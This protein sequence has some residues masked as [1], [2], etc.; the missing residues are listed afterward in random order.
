MA[1]EELRRTKIVAMIGPASSS[2]EAICALIDAGVDATRL[3]FSHG[4][5]E[6][7]AAR[8]GLVREAQE[9]CGRPIALIAD[10]QG[11]KLRI[12]DLPGSVTLFRGQ[13]VVVT[14]DGPAAGGGLPVLPS[15][16][17]E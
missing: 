6:E 4:T 3:N 11:P 12:G 7:H 14:G 16:I 2:R 5:R 13:D 9:E 8:A 10:L 15:V 1:A 17:G